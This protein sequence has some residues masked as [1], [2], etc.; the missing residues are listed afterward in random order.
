MS[1]PASR[2]ASSARNVSVSLLAQILVILLGFVTRTVF[3]ATLGVALLGVNSLIISVLAMLTFADLGI[4]GAVMYTLY[5]PLRDGDSSRIAAIVNHAGRMFRRVSAVVGVLGLAA[6]PFIHRLV[7]LEQTVPNLEIYYLVLLANTVAGYLMLNRIVLLEADQRMYVTKAYSM[8][9]NVVRSIAQIAVLLVFRSFLAYLA[10]QVIATVANNLV[11]YLRAGRLYP[12]LTAHANPL[13]GAERR[14]MWDSVRAMTL[15]RFAGLILGN[16]P[17]IL[18]SVVV[19]TMALGYYSNY[20]L[21]VGAV[22]MLTETAFGALTPSVGSFAAAGDRQA[23]RRLFDEIVVLS[24]LIHGA[25]AC[26]LVALIGDFVLLWLG[27]EFV[28]PLEVVAAIVLNFYVSGSLMPL[29]SFRSATGLFRETQYVIVLTAV[30]SVGLSILLGSAIGLAG[31][32]VSPALA[33]LVTI[34][35]YEPLVLVRR[36]LAGPVLPH[37]ALQVG[38]LALWTAIA[39]A[40]TAAGQL[41]P[42]GTITAMALKTALLAVVVPAAGW[43]A[44]RRTDG[45]RALGVRVR[46]F[47]T[48]ARSRGGQVSP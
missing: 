45:F 44:F 9:F 18:I 14:S 17:A 43:L 34:A 33:R 7:R 28:L 3:V 27:A 40:V 11:V 20:I 26:G 25:L 21:I 36:H 47:A 46:A 2:T 19:G 13:P 6:T 38:S 5:A 32:V 1:A 41:V 30:L 35:W 48:A 8:A 4:N 23:G 39:I 29:W 15:Y 16:S 31:V 24:V 22:M 42:G 37:L 12:S 10:I